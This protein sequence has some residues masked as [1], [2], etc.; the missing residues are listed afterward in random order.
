MQAPTKRKNLTRALRS[1]STLKTELIF[2][3]ETS[4]DFRRIIEA[5]KRSQ[6]YRG[7]FVETRRLAACFYTDV[8]L[9]VC[10]ALRDVPDIGRLFLQQCR[11]L[12]IKSCLHLQALD[13]SVL[14]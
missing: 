3:S 12:T 7:L 9:F 1:Y 4:L 13:S 5:F 10:V 2:S 6:A 11:M 14:G 8:T